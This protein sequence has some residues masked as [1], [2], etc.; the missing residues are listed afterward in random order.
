MESAGDCI[1]AATQLGLAGT[2]QEEN[3]VNYAQET[4]ASLAPNCYFLSK[5]DKCCNLWFNKDYAATGQC[6]ENV[7]CLCQDDTGKVVVVFIFLSWL[8]S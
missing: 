6:S 2:L 5:G 4:R 8:N 7:V 1:E 3:S